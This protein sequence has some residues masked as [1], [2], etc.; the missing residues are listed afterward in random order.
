MKKLTTVFSILA[1]S[2]A[3]GACKGSKSS[4]QGTPKATE[5]TPTPAPAPTTT[6]PTPAPTTATPTTP[7]PAPT[8]T[9]PAPTTAA[10]TGIAECDAYAAAYD[11]FAACDK[12]PAATKDASKTSIEQMRQ[13]WASLK[14]P[15]TPEAS[16]K[17]AA[18]AC[19][20]ATSALQQSA[21]ALGCDI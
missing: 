16:K 15:A 21:K 4:D 2:A 8:G 18:D 9:P 12:V 3:L 13:S 19:K 14:D 7:T 17:A 6:T 5:T 1:L 11:K 20:T 10:D